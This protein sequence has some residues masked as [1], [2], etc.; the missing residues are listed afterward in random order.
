MTIDQ[1]CNQD[2]VEGRQGGEMVDDSM[3]QAE[4]YIS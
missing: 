3:Y 1:L 4:S 2:Q